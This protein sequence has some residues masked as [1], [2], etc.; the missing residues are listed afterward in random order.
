MLKV[1]GYIPKII[2]QR[3]PKTSSEQ[4]ISETILASSYRRAQTRENC[5]MAVVVM[6][7]T[8]QE[9]CTKSLGRTNPSV[10]KV[11]ISPVIVEVMDMSHTRI[12]PGTRWR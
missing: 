4:R 3:N 12:T 11:R 10:D 7:A 2:C 1:S 9:V 8:M 5:P 6:R